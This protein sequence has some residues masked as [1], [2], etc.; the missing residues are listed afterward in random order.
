[1]PGKIDSCPGIGKLFT[2]FAIGKSCVIGVFVSDC[3]MIDL[4]RASITNVGSFIQT[5]ASFLFKV[6]A[7]L[8]TR[9]TG[10]TLNPAKNNLATGIGLLTVITMD[11]EV[12]RII[13]GALMV[14]VR[15]TVSLYLF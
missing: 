4:L 8:I 10:S 15:K 6:F 5:A 1:M 14:P 11:T 7:G 9:W 3:A 12:L 2:I 13:K